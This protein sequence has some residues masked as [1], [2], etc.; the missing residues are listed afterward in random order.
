MTETLPA[1]LATNRFASLLDVL[2]YIANEYNE[3][4]AFSCFGHTLSY[5][6]IDD[7]SNRFANYL[8]N[9]TDLKPGDRIAIQLPNLLQFPV[10]AYGA[11]K[12]GLII[13]NTNPLYT[14]HEMEHQFKDSGVKAI[15]IL[16]NFCDKLEEII[17]ETDISTVIVTQIG[18]LQKPAKRLLLNS[19]AR[20][21]KKMVPA[22]S[23]PNTIAL[24]SLMNNSSARPELE[25]R[26]GD[27]DLAV[28]LYTGGT[29]G[30]AKGAMLSH[31]NL[32]ANMMQMRHRS[33]ETVRNGKETVL[34][35]LPLY[36]SYA[37][38][39]HCWI[40]AF[41]G[42]HNLL[43][44]NPRDLDSVIKT[45]KDYVLTGMVGINTLFVALLARSDIKSVN[46]SSLRFT[47]AGGMPMTVSVARQW[48][49]LTGSEIFEGYG[50]TECSPV[51]SINP[52]G[53]VKLGTVG[54][55]LAETQIRVVDDD[56]N[57]VAKGERGELWVKGPQ[58]M[59]G[60]WSADNLNSTIDSDDNPINNDGWLVTGDLVEVDEDNYIRIVDRKKDMILV[61]GFNVFPY[62]VEEWV[63]AHPAI[64]E[65]AAIG[66]PSEKTGESIK[67]FVVGNGKTV[68]EEEILAY[69]R[70][71]LTSY[72]L[73]REIVFVDDLPKTNI[74]K[75]LRREL[76]PT[77]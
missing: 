30:V 59:L 5:G 74:G 73:P 25:G 53:R 71:G 52:A 24:Q 28:I 22:H 3:S 27:D 10:V 1:E 58:V 57:D 66:V 64:A 8:L 12:A 49:E 77:S 37:F 67:L 18:D 43:V 47:G 76:K 45:M 65:S 55:P 72:K 63:N 2:D 31:R 19:A 20:Y 11:M 50:L 35:P 56:E 7:Y 48:H 17:A 42:N 54:P 26:A 33:G 75:I 23:L 40:M 21:L 68:S 69:C 61:S 41:T 51:V 46:F 62:E 9:G 4:P 36:H 70:E 38:L 32:I 60:Y 15:V 16:A 14:A 6:Q 39:F 29:T 13:V 44:P 34:A